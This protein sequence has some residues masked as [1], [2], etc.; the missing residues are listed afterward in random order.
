MIGH[1]HGGLARTIAFDD[2]GFEVRTTMK[3]PPNVQ[4]FGWN[5]VTSIIAFKLDCF[6][7]DVICMV[8][9]NGTTA[10]LITEEDTGWEEF[11]SALEKLL[12]VLLNKTEWW[13]TV[14]H[15]AFAT[16]ATTIL[17]REPEAREPA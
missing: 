7:H 6:A 14:A 12:P 9:G 10:I 11:T 3:G 17:C 4:R 5:S 1:S 13:P 8:V 15:P 16:N 2:A